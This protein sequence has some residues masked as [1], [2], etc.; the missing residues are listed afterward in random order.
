MDGRVCQPRLGQEHG[1]DLHRGGLR[2]HEAAAPGAFAI[3]AET[4]RQAVFLEIKGVLLIARG[5]IRRRVERLG[6]RGL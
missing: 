4:G 2:A 1:V 5:M 3:E 6:N